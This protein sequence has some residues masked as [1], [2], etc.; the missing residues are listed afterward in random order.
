MAKL[1][2][3]KFWVFSAVFLTFGGMTF[4]PWTIAKLSN[5]A[6]LLS[7]YTSSTPNYQVLASIVWFCILVFFLVWRMIWKLP[8]LGPWLSRVIFPDLNGDW[9]VEVK[10]NWP[11]IDKMRNAAKDDQVPRFDP[12][13]EAHPRPQLQLTEFVATIEQRWLSTEIKF[14]PNHKTPLLNSVTL[15]ADLMRKE[16][17]E[18][19]RIALIYK[20]ENAAVPAH[21]D[22][23][24]F[25]GAALLQVSDDGNSLYGKYWTNR[26]WDKGLNAAG[27]IILTRAH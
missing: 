20:Q 21:T 3:L 26:S 13:S 8:M 1:L 25:L 19:K 6:P 10:S 23:N 12:V 7:N 14:K 15:S 16:G 5:M 22:E 11:I 9:K 27:E 18:P 24:S 4:W 2:G 17:S